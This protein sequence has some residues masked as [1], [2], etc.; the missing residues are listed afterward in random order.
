MTYKTRPKPEPYDLIVLHKVVPHTASLHVSTAFRE[1]VDKHWGM[2]TC[3][4]PPEPRGCLLDSIAADMS[5]SLIVDATL[6]GMVI[7]F[8]WMDD[9]NIE[10][11]KGLIFQNLT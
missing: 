10:R 3:M 7:C 8:V 5:F 11:R 1:Y 2:Q 6:D 4:S 9:E